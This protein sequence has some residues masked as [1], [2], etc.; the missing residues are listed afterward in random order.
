MPQ[1]LR[2]RDGE[3]EIKVSL[4]TIEPEE[5]PELIGDIALVLTGVA[6]V[7]Q[8]VYAKDPITI[9]IGAIQI[10]EAV[11]DIKRILET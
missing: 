4:Q 5:W 6:A 7:V 11:L 2:T 1:V 9:G 3:F 10:A 8:G